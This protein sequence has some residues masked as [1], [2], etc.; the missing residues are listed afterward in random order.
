MWVLMQVAP[1]GGPV[2]WF[3]EVTLGIG[4]FVH[5]GG[6]WAVHGEDQGKVPVASWACPLTDKGTKRQQG[7]ALRAKPA[8][9]EGAQ[10]GFRFLGE[11]GLPRGNME[12][13]TRI[14]R[15]RSLEVDP[16]I[17]FDPKQPRNALSPRSRVPIGSFS[18]EKRKSEPSW[19]SGEQGSPSSLAWD[20]PCT[21][22]A[23]N[24]AIRKLMG[25]IT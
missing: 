11:E 18:W 8:E 6:G 1:F 24:P 7:R 19:A 12:W 21:I 16:K 17:G 15:L 20:W 5:R 10:Q 14:I 2:M 9:G 25:W 22:W 13:K 3:T 4:L 23:Q